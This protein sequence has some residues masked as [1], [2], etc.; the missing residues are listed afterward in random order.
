[1]RVFTDEWTHQYEAARIGLIPCLVDK[2]LLY[3]SITRRQLYIAFQK[4]CQYNARLAGKR[5]AY[6][7]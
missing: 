6:A 3:I 1:M 5:Y 7:T 2:Q 4:Y